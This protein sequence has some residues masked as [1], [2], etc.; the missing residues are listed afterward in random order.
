MTRR[1][2]LGFDRTI[3]LEWLDATAAKVADGASDAEVRTYLME[4]LKGEVAGTGAHGAIGKTVTVL[5][6]IWSRVPPE[7]APLRARALRALPTVEAPDRL[8]LHWAMAMATYPFFSDAAAVVGR[9]LRLQGEVSLPAVTRRLAAQ[10][11]DRSTMARA[12]PRVVSSMAQW[13]ALQGTGRR[14]M[15]RPTL[16][17]RSVA[18]PLAEVLVEALLLDLNG[19]SLPLTHLETH[20]AFFPFSIRLT[21]HELRRSRLFALHRQGLDTDVIELARATVDG[22]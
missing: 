17:P 2:R 8:A 5:S 13:R 22:Q 12:V 19:R 3:A 6:H 11:G 9:V 20:P 4:V 18:G 10:W 15:Y 21:A 7:C 14:G 1:A 16:P